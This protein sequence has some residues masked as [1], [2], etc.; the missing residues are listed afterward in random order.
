MINFEKKEILKK[1]D[2]LQK[3]IFKYKLIIN[4]YRIHLKKTTNKKNKY[5]KALTSQLTVMKSKSIKF[6]NFSERKKTK[7]FLTILNKEKLQ[8]NDNLK[9]FG[10]NQNFKTKSFFLKISKE[11]KGGK[12]FSHLVPNFK[13][14]VK[15]LKSSFCISNGEEVS[16]EVEDFNGKGSKFEI[17]LDNSI[18]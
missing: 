15:D 14:N 6:E 7:N 1:V 10:K 11:N 8:K 2:I 18:L 9:F 13:G 16:D 4:K 5:F 17:K 3:K 12:K